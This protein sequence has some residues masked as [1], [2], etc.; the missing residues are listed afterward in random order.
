MLVLGA[1]QSHAYIIGPSSAMM[2]AKTSEPIICKATQYICS[3][4]VVPAISPYPTCGGAQKQPQ[5][6]L[7]IAIDGQKIFVIKYEETIHDAEISRR[8]ELAPQHGGGSYRSQACDL[9][10]RN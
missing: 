4:E 6:R 9:L 10:G 7:S 1:V 5:G 3:A 8:A 2:A